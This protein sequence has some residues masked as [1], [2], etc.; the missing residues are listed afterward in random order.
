M[1]VN[2]DSQK[3]G[4]SIFRQILVHFLGKLFIDGDTE[5]FERVVTFL[6][7]KLRIRPLKV[8]ALPPYNHHEKHPNLKIGLEKVHF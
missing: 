7:T 4:S 5:G 1:R 2:S 3:V 6:R 8:V